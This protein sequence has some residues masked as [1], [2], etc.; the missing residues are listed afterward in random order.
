[1]KIKVLNNLFVL[2]S[3]FLLMSAC[4]KRV[5]N[6]NTNPS[7]SDR[8]SIPQFGEANTFEVAVWNIENFG[9]PAYHSDVQL[10]IT[11]VV[12]IIK[13]LDIDLFGVEEIG[14]QTAFD[15]V[16]SRLEEYNGFLANFSGNQRTGIF[17]RKSLISILKDTLLFEND[18]NS[19]PRPPLMLYL[20]AQ[21]GNQVFDFNFIVIHLKAYPDQESEDRRRSAIQKMEQFISTSIQQG[22][23][24][25]FVVGGDWND[26]LDDP[27]SNNVFL[28]FLNKQPQD[29]MFLTWPYRNTDYSYIP[30]S[31]RS[32]IDHI[33]VT[34]S[35]DTSYNNET[36]IL[37]I[38]QFFTQY[39]LEVSDH[40]PVASKFSVF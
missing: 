12:E 13:D 34:A 3:L 26:E 35:I 31:F 2:V 29:Y 40:R 7:P 8:I 10:Q 18:F 30:S 21:R 17:Y 20:K 23:D 19:F 9:N 33:M 14:S 36:Q 11:D 1:M 16:A 39:L 32:L 15:S 22:G 6:D 24:P 5:N 38:D 27:A 37:K 28:P 4:N 25:D